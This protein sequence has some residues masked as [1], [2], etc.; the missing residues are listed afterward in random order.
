MR[1]RGALAAGFAALS[2]ARLIFLLTA[3]A[4]VLGFLSAAPLAPAMTEAFTGT[5]AGDHLLRNHPE[6]APV[7]ALDFMREK[8]AAVAGARES[9]IWAALFG[10]LLQIFFAGG[11]V[12]TLGR[13]VFSIRGRR[14]AFW[15]GCRRHFAHN[16]KCF[17]L[18][19]LLAGVSL[20]VFLGIARALRKAI[21]AGAPPHPGGSTVWAIAV[22]V[23]SLWIFGALTLLYDFARAGRRSTPGI[24]A[25][26]AF[27]KARRRLR[28]LGFRG[29]GV[30]LFWSAAALAALAVVFAAAWG[31]RTPS[32]PAVAVN[33]L[34]LVLLLA[35]RPAAR[36]AA[37]GSV[38]ALFD[39]TEP[40]ELVPLGPSVPAPALPVPPPGVEEGPSAGPVED[41]AEF[42]PRSNADPSGEIPRGE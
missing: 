12:E 32:G 33:L 21:F 26:A 11:I 31:Q 20:G 29:L 17:A 9:V 36:V 34:L 7:D 2:R 35:V 1:A 24:G 15:A 16:L 14:A 22:W 25:F 13:D 42:G 28:G 18:F 37:W 3:C 5:L 6:F 8:S 4:I 10:V 40:R 27:R 19:A 38:L 39:A 23:V 41:E 30:L